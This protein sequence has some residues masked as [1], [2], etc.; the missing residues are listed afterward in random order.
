TSATG[1]TVAGS[2]DP[3]TS[4]TDPTASVAV[5]NN[6]TMNVSGGGKRVASL[7]GTG[8]TVITGNTPFTSAGAIAQTFLA[9]DG[10]ISVGGS[11]SVGTT[12]LGPAAS[13][14]FTVAAGATYDS[15]NS[16][17][18]QNGTV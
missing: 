3:F 15:T 6:G 2:G 4:S 9:T 17:L 10:P 12:F 18:L 7:A 16:F 14:D 5:I 11:S 8:A 13:L 1:L